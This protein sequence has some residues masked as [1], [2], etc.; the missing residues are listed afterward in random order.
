MTCVR[1]AMPLTAATLTSA[2]AEIGASTAGP[3]VAV[4]A[5]PVCKAAVTAVCLSDAEIAALRQPTAQAI[6]KNNVGLKAAC[7]RV[8]KPCPRA[9]DTPAAH[10]PPA[11]VS[12]PKTS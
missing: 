11:P 9:G 12:E 5:D 8:V 6:A 1:L 4:T 2:C 10:R 3:T 7:P